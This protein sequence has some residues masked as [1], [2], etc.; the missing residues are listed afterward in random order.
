MFLIEPIA[1]FSLF[2]GYW[3]TKNRSG[4]H[5]VKGEFVSLAIPIGFGATGKKGFT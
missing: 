1:D 3:P 5:D 2:L 4:D